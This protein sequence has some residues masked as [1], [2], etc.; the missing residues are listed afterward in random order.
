MKL[1]FE[2]LSPAEGI[3]IIRSG[4]TLRLVRPRMR[5][6]IRRYWL[7][8]PFKIQSCGMAFPPL[9]SSSKIGIAQ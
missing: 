4:Q 5:R 7:R 6:M 2:A 8:N 1:K 9:G 3:G